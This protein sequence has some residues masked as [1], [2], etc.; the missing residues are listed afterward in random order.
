MVFT[1]ASFYGQIQYARNI[2]YILTRYWPHRKRASF[3]NLIYLS[4]VKAL[5]FTSF[6]VT[7]VMLCLGLNPWD[8]IRFHRRQM[9]EELDILSQQQIDLNGSI[10]QIVFS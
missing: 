4:T 2:D 8:E 7:G 6:F 10:D 1:A 9:N 5:F 3:R